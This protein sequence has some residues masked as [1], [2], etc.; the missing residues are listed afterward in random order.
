MIFRKHDILPVYAAGSDFNVS[1]LGMITNRKPRK[2]DI[3]YYEVTQRWDGWEIGRAFTIS[4]AKDM[5]LKFEK[6]GVT[7]HG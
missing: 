6:L 1:D 3:E 4:E 7:Y 2:E 5:V